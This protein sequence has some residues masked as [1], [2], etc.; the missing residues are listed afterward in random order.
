MKLFDILV[1]SALLI[2]LPAMGQGLHQEIEVEREI[3]PVERDAN[4]INTLPALSLPPVTPAKLKLSERIVTAR[5]PNNVSV[6]E[7]AA[8]GDSLEPSP[9]RG[10][11]ALGIFPLYNVDFS[12]G[13]AAVKNSDTQLNFWTQYNG[14][15]Y[16]RDRG[17]EYETRY[18]RDHTVSVGTTLSQ[19]IGRKSMLRASADYT[20]ASH[21]I[22]PFDEPFH[23]QLNSDRANI[24]AAFGSRCEGLRY[25]IGAKFGYFGYSPTETDLDA[26]GEYNYGLDLEGSI[27][28]GETSDFRLG[29][30]VEIL[31]SRSYFSVIEDA[32]VGG[33][34]RGLVD[35]TPAYRFHGTNFEAQLGA[36]LGISINDG[37]TFHAAPDVLLGWHPSSFFAISA[38]ATGGV[39]VNS[40]A[41]LN[42]VTPYCNPFVQYSSSNIPYDFGATVTV[43]LFRGAYI[44][45]S[46]FYAKAN[47]WLMPSL[48]QEWQ[49]GQSFVPVDVSGWRAGVTMGYDYR[50]FASVALSYETAPGDYDDCYYLWR[51]R[52]R[53]V[54]NGQ[55]TVRPIENFSVTAGMEWRTGRRILYRFYEPGTAIPPVE[56]CENLKNI[57]NLSLGFAYDYT[58]ALTFFVR[59][60]NLLNHRHIILGDR[61]SNGITPLLG[62]TYKF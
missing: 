44:S 32:N 49:G 31:S 2:A 61:I 24:R 56:Y 5:V 17:P 1:P 60:E 21:T 47:D 26:A 12:A 7:P 22:S 43:G 36:R 29:A 59:G 48:Q 10:Y 34:T 45:L 28:A 42:D 50:D 39:K 14:L 38:T 41:S 23:Y 30:D 55:L 62:A 3:V 35:V 57:S 25:S 52:A 53:H 8:Y 16:R 33:K 46:G 51:D 58:P 11:V 54:F 20:F 19:K 37:K 13:Y 15:L 6:L 18:W 40:L 4:R 27:G 9:Y